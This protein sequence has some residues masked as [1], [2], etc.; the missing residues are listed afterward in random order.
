[1]GDSTLEEVNVMKDQLLPNFS[2]WL[3]FP[4]TGKLEFG[5]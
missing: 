1:M 3:F 5:P 4:K 2:N